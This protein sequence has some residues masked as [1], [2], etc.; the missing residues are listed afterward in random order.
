MMEQQL[1]APGA[2]RPR[3][4]FYTVKCPDCSSELVV[5]SRPSTTVHCSICGA[6][7]ATPTGGKG[8]FRA[9]IVRTEV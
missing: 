2:P 8:E 7:V 1:P 9:E 5:F 6:L 4:P 3:A